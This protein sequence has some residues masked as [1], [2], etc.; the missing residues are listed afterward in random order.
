MSEKFLSTAV[1]VLACG[2]SAMAQF[3]RGGSQWA[4]VGGDPQRTGWVRADPQISK[5]FG[6]ACTDER[7][8]G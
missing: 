6:H 5:A 2:G 1:L 3:G 7:D 4:T 8:R